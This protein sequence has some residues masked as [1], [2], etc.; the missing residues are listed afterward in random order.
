MECGHLM[1]FANSFYYIRKRECVNRLTLNYSV[2]NMNK[3]SV[4]IVGIVL[5]STNRDFVRIFFRSL[6]GHEF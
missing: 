1:N 3:Y 2:R 4:E 5:F 6:F